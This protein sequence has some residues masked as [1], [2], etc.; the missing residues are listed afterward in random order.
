M[1]GDDTGSY[2]QNQDADKE[3]GGSAI[4]CIDMRHKIRFGD[5]N[6][7]EPINT[8]PI[9]KRRHLQELAIAINFELQILC[10]GY[11]I[12]ITKPLFQYFSRIL[13]NSSDALIGVNPPGYFVSGQE[14][15]GKSNR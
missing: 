1:G 10:S 14:A 3:I 8:V 7:N 13:N 11:A 12:I 9:F 4:G 2:D 5:D 6:H 15:S